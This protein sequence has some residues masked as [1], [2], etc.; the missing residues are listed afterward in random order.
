MFYGEIILHKAGLYVIISG[1]I[2][3]NHQL[4]QVKS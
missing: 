1:L 4:T 3:D 2:T